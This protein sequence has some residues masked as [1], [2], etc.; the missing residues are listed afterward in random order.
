MCEAVAQWQNWKHKLP[1]PPSHTENPIWCSAGCCDA[2]KSEQMSD[3]KTKRRESP[4]KGSAAAY[5]EPEGEHWEAQRSDP[6]RCLHK[7]RCFLFTDRQ[8]GTKP[9]TAKVQASRT[10]SLTT[11]QGE[12]YRSTVH[13]FMYFCTWYLVSDNFSILRPDIGTGTKYWYFIHTHC[14]VTHWLHN[15]I[16]IVAWSYLISALMYWNLKLNCRSEGSHLILHWGHWVLVR[17]ENM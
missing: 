16:V 12:E 8:H 10:R 7:W 5:K 3:G 13:P 2:Y 1:P 9:P 11:T 17:R 6:W 15:L 14:S 4:S